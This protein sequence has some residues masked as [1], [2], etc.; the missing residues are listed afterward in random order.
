MGLT[1]LVTTAS[2]TKKLLKPKCFIIPYGV[3][4]T[5]VNMSMQTSRYTRDTH[6][7]NRNTYAMFPTVIR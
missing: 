1:L 7:P 3:P 6:Q 4:M 5:V 2:I